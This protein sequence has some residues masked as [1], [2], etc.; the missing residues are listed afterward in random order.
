MN[1]WI[2]RQQFAHDPLHR[3]QAQSLLHGIVIDGNSTKTKSGLAHSKS[4][5]IRHIP[6]RRDHPVPS[7]LPRR[8]P[9]PSTE[10]LRPEAML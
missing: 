5:S 9:L 8:F 10:D 2:V 6:P 7:D 4:W 3:P 1:L